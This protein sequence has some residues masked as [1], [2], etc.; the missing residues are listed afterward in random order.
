M[1][2]AKS[3]SCTAEY[4]IFGKS[5]KSVHTFFVCLFWGGGVATQD[6]ADRAALATPKGVQGYCSHGFRLCLSSRQGGGPHL[7][8]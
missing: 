6:G 3:I 5:V 1:R 4:T 7:D 8:G 2:R